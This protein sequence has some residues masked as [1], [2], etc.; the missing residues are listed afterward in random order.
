M[1]NDYESFRLVIRD[2]A[3]LMSGTTAIDRVADESVHSEHGGHVQIFR[4]EIPA[5]KLRWRDAVLIVALALSCFAV[6]LGWQAERE[7]RLAEYYGID[8]EVYIA[9]QH[10]TPPQDP[11]RKIIKEK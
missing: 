2:G 5:D 3:R 8:L 6:A 10:L 11:W 4:L 1:A 7:A 9:K